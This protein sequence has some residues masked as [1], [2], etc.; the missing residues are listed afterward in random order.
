MPKIFTILEDEFA[1]NVNAKVD[2]NQVSSLQTQ[3]TRLC[4]CAA[5]SD[6][7]VGWWVFGCCLQQA[8]V[9]F[10]GEK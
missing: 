2:N 7:R 3:T 5:G 4:R 10:E 1:W 8:E 6:S 9:L